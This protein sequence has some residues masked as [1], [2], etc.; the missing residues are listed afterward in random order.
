M[1]CL[2]P[3]Q[4]KGKMFYLTDVGKE[5]EKIGKRVKEQRHDYWIDL[6]DF[7]LSELS[8][9]AYTEVE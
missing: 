2:N 9:S 3:S 4:K 1:K 7:L 6:K 5:L 8:S